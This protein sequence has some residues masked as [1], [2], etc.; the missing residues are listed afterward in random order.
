LHGRRNTLVKERIL[1]GRIPPSLRTTDIIVAKI[2]AKT[3]TETMTKTTTKIATKTTA[4]LEDVATFARKRIANH[5]SIQ[6]RNRQERKRPTKAS[7][8]T[9]QTDASTIT[10][11]DSLSNT[12]LS[13]RKG[14]TKT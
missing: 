11:R 1:L 6:T 14:V 3:M 7:S 2:K 13:A 8:I 9:A 10:L 5:G 12:L 4:D